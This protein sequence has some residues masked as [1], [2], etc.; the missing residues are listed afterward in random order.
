MRGQ[1]CSDHAGRLAQNLSLVSRWASVA[2]RRNG[3]GHDAVYL[4]SIQAPTA[5]IGLERLHQAQV[6]AAAYGRA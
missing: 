4:P 6:K 2:A 5:P 3:G 1:S